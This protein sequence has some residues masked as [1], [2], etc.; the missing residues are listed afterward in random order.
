MNEIA[1]AQ[2]IKRVDSLEFE[3]TELKEQYLE[4]SDLLNVLLFIQLGKPNGL[5]DLKNVITAKNFAFLDKE[6]VVEML[7][8]FIKLH[9]I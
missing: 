9:T 1:V 8:D 6:S 7:E 4:T 2:L 5:A 3:L